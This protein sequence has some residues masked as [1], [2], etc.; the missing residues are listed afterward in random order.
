M[1]KKNRSS[2][3]YQSIFNSIKAE[4]LKHGRP[5]M[6]VP[7][8]NTNGPSNLP[9]HTVPTS[10]Q[11]AAPNITSSFIP[12]STIRNKI[13]SVLPTKQPGYYVSPGLMNQKIRGRHERG[14]NDWPKVDSSGFAPTPY[15]LNFPR[16]VQLIGN[17][18]QTGQPLQQC[19]PIRFQPCGIGPPEGMEESS[20]YW[21]IDES[22]NENTPNRSPANSDDEY[23]DDGNP[24]GYD[25]YTGPTNNYSDS[26]DENDDQVK[27]FRVK[28]TPEAKRLGKELRDIFLSRIEEAGSSTKAGQPQTSE[29]PKISDKVKGMV[30]FEFLSKEVLLHLKSAQSIKR[31]E[32]M[33]V[34]KNR[35]D[36]DQRG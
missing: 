28:R 26:D 21:E 2:E 25:V 33:W 15:E 34:M 16:H 29:T 20:E 12:Q 30:V 3:S 17:H 4:K 1:T 18:Y 14:P 24:F 13:N 23:F 5:P 19:G 27:K 7:R 31:M 32:L 22:Y 9:S 8:N 11:Q 6:D 36:S 10:A 35:W